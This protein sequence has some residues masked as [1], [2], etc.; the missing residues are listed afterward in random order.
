[1]QK[2]QLKSLRKNTGKIWK[3]LE[4][5]KRKREY[6]GEEN[7]QNDLQQGSYLVGQI[8]GMIRNIGQDQKGIGDDGKKK[9]QRDKK[10]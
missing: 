10:Q 2:K 5:R 8:K 9:E 6:L 4:G 7:Y 3:T 1:M